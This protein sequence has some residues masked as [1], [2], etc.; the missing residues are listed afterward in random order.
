MSANKEYTLFHR[1]VPFTLPGGAYEERDENALCWL[2]S[3]LM[4][5][6]SKFIDGIVAYLEQENKAFGSLL[7]PE[8]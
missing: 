2:H 5:I 3:F 8:N 6:P 7:Q 1:M 4:T